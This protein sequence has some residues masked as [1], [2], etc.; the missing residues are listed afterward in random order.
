MR[1]ALVVA[2]EI[3][4]TRR[5][6]KERLKRQEIDLAL[7]LDDVPDCLRK[8]TIFEFLRTLPWQ[9]PVRAAKLLAACSISPATTLGQLTPKERSRLLGALALKTPPS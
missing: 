3:R 5:Q 8:M 2:S 6:I 1:E 7:L 9:G 4:S